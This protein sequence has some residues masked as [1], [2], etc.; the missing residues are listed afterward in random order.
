[1]RNNYVDRKL[2]IA[3]T[4]EKNHKDINHD[5]IRKKNNGVRLQFLFVLVKFIHSKVIYL[6]RQNRNEVQ[7][8][9]T[10]CK[11]STYSSSASNISNH[12]ISAKKIYTYFLKKKNLCNRFIDKFL[13]NCDY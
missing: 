12:T 2:L 10:N 7:L 4:K 9:S 6:K 1:M 5:Y 8:L 13:H 11:L 3:K